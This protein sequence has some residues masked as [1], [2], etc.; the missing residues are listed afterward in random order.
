MSLRARVVAV[1]LAF[2]AVPAAARDVRDALDAGE[3]ICEFRAGWKRSVIADLLRDPP[4]AVERMM[5]YEAVGTDR[6]KVISTRAPGR[7]DVE[8]RATGKAVHLM[9]R[10]GP[11]LLVT[12]LTR[13]VRTA[14]KAGSEICVRYAARHAWHFY[15]AAL[16][17]PDAAFERLPSGSLTGACEPWQ[18]P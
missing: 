10:A 5:V 15:L 12:T 9:E 18:M 1:A 6:A 17:E 8:V 4:P 2:A 11:S 3:L 14:W 7:R 16:R 13:C